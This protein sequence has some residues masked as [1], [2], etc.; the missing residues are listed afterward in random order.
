MKRVYKERLLKLAN[1]LRNLPNKKFDLATFVKAEEGD[2]GELRLP[3]LDSDCKSTGCAIGWCPTVFPRNCKYILRNNVFGEEEVIVVPAN[4]EGDADY[5]TF[6][7]NFFGLSEESD[8]YY[9]FTPQAYRSGHRGPKSVANR[10]I[11][12]VHKNGNVNHDTQAYQRNY[13]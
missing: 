12:F 13:Y 7:L 10:I 1:F 8:A 9:L 6:A 11:D 3:E 5:W 4:D 2:Y